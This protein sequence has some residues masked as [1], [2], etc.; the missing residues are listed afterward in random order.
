M[1]LRSLKGVK[2]FSSQH[3]LSFPGTQRK[4]LTSGWKN[5][6][7]LPRLCLTPL[8][9]FGV[10]RRGE[11]APIHRL[12]PIRV[13]SAVIGTADC[14]IHLV[15]ISAKRP[16]NEFTAMIQESEAM[17]SACRDVD[18]RARSQRVLSVTQ[19][20][21]NHAFQV[22]PRFMGF[23]MPVKRE[24]RPLGAAQNRAC[25]WVS[26]IFRAC[27]HNGQLAVEAIA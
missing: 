14:G 19:D 25:H 1:G 10:D 20:N 26:E 4:R 24:R 9:D 6:E 11:P 2:L 5:A 7:S 21:R 3:S 22:E 15:C 16:R 27:N 8:E 17:R 23:R 13:N 12:V 18:L